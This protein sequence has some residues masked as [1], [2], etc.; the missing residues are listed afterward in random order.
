LECSSSD[1]GGDTCSRASA[2][3]PDD[4]LRE[5][6]DFMLS[7][8]GMYDGFQGA[9]GACESAARERRDRLSCWSPLRTPMTV[10]EAL[11][12]HTL[13]VQKELHVSAVIANRVHRRRAPTVLRSADRSRRPSSGW[14]NGPPIWSGAWRGGADAQLLWDKD[15]EQA[16]G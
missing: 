6:A 11:H 8:S 5:L 2:D 16:G 9:R 1:L 12:F 7:L 4:T 10:E 3:S 13:L 14:P 15:Q